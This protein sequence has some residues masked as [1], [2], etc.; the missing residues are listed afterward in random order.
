MHPMSWQAGSLLFLGYLAVATLLIR[1]LTRTRRLSAMAFIASGAAVLTLSWFL[2]PSHLLNT[3]ILP[4]SLLLIGYWASG[5][6]FVAPMPVLEEGLIAIDRALRIDEIAVRLPAAVVELLEIAYTFVYPLMPIG[7]F[8]ALREGIP[9]ER[10]WTVVLFTDF[11]CFGMMPF[12]QTRPPRSVGIPVPWQSRWRA[13]NLQVL[14]ASS[15]QANTFP[16]GH[17]AEGLAVALILSGA[18]GPVPAVM[19]IC[20]FAISAGAVFGRYHYAADALAGWAVALA[21]FFSTGR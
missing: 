21:V 7:V 19:F 13:L 20:A 6:L 17:A 4:P 8:L 15:V 14:D 12:F 11:I 18:S 9:V 16:S 3:W 5:R 1:G 2:P 10:F